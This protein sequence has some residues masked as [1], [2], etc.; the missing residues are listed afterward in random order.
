LFAQVILYWG[1]HNKVFQLNGMK[2][3]DMVEVWHTGTELAE[4]MVVITVPF[5]IIW[6][7]HNPSIAQAGIGSVLKACRWVALLVLVYE[8]SSSMN[9]G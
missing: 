1:L 5:T 2:F 9:L 4:C 3:D 7:H 6:W 8:P